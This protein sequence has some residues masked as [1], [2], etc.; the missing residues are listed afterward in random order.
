MLVDCW[1]EGVVVELLKEVNERNAV[2]ASTEVLIGY[3]CYFHEK[4]SSALG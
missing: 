3:D 2:I 4:S 1:E